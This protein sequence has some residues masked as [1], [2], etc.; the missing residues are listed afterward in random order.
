LKVLLIGE[1]S[2]LHNSLK[3]GLVAL[4]HEVTI[5]SNGDGFKKYPIDFSIEAKIS[6]ANFNYYIRQIILRFFTFDLARLEQGIRFYFHLSKLKNFDVVQLINESPIQT[7][8]WLEKYLLR[9]IKVQNKKLFL[10]SSGVDSISVQFLLDKKIEKSILNP[11]FDDNTLVKEYDYVLDYVSKKHQSLHRLVYDN[12]LGI[13]AS[14]IDYVLPLLGNK[15]F[16]GLIPNPVNHHEI[17]Y[18]FPEIKNKIIIFLGVNQWNQHQKGISYFKKALEVIQT[19]FTDKVAIIIAE[20][21]PYSE[22]IKSYDQAHILLDQC[23]AYDQGYN[24]LE[25]MAKGK[26]V[27]TGAEKEFL[28]H[29]NL[30]EKE[31]C[32]NA[33]ADVD[34]LVN[35]LS[36]LIE[37]PE[38]ITQISKN[39]RA[40]IEREH[41]YIKIAAKYLEVWNNN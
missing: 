19:K 40:F 39:A 3:E 4:G 21:L 28:E 32:I 41:D 23:F 37:N 25:A 16:L 26:V 12:C 1:Y 13:I 38:N 33:K 18:N 5:V 14:D 27:F 11:Y 34:Y 31:V 15:K 20:N 2:R 36:F 30:S 10:L 7:S 29:Y 24:A 35:Q 22:Y 8:V 17:G 9:K 6:N